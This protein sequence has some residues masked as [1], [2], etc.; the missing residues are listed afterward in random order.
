[1]GIH[2][3][4]SYFPSPTYERGYNYYRQGRV[5]NIQLIQKVKGYDGISSTVVGSQSYRVIVKIF[6]PENKI[7]ISGICSCPVAMNC[8]HVVATLLKATDEASLVSSTPQLDELTHTERDPKIDY[9]LQKLSHSLTEE[10]KPSNVIDETH[11]LFYILSM[12]P[13][14]LTELQVELFLVKRLKS[15]NLGASKNLVQQQMLSSNTFIRS[16][17]SY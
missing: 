10:K 16:I 5:K 14:R 17:K 4:K 12:L 8:K 9:F 1:M 11:H 7:H 6:G 3:I 15:G 2:R 13:H